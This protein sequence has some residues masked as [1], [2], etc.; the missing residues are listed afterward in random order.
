M[1]TYI[2]QPLNRQSTTLNIKNGN[3]SAHLKIK[4]LISGAT[5]VL[6]LHIEYREY[7]YTYKHLNIQEFRQ[8][9]AA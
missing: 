2:P 8:K 1:Y 4:Y 7:I 9:S 3:W 6:A 5:T